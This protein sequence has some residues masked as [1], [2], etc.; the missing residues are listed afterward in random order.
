MLL[1]D[2][3]RLRVE[4][5]VDTPLGIEGFRRLVAA[6]QLHHLLGVHTAHHKQH[7]ILGMV[8]GMV[9]LI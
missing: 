4:K 3:G 6:D 9:T 1:A 2:L 8:K 5:P 7:H